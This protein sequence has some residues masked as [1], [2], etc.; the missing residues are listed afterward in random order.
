VVVVTIT[1][2]VPQPL[3]SKMDPSALQVM[4]WL[5][6]AVYVGV[7]A[8]LAVVQGIRSLQPPCG[9]MFILCNTDV[10]LIPGETDTG[11]FA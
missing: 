7:E 10:S 8:Q 2:L 5:P 1:A 6:I 4:F 3:M 9:L 11:A